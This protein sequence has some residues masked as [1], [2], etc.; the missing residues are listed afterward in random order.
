MAATRARFISNSFGILR[1]SSLSS[2]GNLIGS[3]IGYLSIVLVLFNSTGIWSPLQCGYYYTNG[4]RY[5]SNQ[6]SSLVNS[7]DD[8]FAVSSAIYLERIRS[9]DTWHTSWMHITSTSD[10]THEHLNSL[11]CRKTC[12]MQ[13]CSHR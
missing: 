2:G 6:S 8:A 3:F 7:F 9:L 4:Y 13:A 10:H 1:C 5:I 11:L 12:L